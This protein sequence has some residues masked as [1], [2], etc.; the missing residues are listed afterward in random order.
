[1]HRLDQPARCE[2]QPPPHLHRWLRDGTA[3]AS[4]VTEGR[5]A[6]LCG[7]HDAHRDAAL[8]L[9]DL[10]GL[11]PARGLAAWW[12]DLGGDWRGAMAVVVT[13]V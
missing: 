9:T 5:S 11:R 12:R 6:N 10:D 1:M 7:M 13:E 3:A 4:V 8:R 2:G